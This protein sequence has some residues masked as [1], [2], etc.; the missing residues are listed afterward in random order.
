[1]VA[2][3][4]P[5]G[6]I[7]VEHR[8]RDIRAVERRVLSVLAQFAAIAA[9][10]MRNAV[11]LRHVQDLA[12]RDSLTGV[13]NRYMFQRALERELMPEQMAKR[14]STTASAVLF[15]DLDDFKVVNDTL[16]HAAGDSLLVAVTERIAA[17]VRQGDLVARLGGDEFAVLIEDDAELNRSCAMAERLVRDLGRPYALGEHQVTVTVSIGLASARGSNETVGDVVRN[18]DMAMYMAKANGKAGFAIFDPGMHAAIRERHEL[19]AQLQRAVELEQLRLVYQPIVDLE[20]GTLAGVEALV[21]WEHPERGLVAP[22][23]FIE[24]AE[25]NGAIL[26]IGRWVLREACRD[27]TRWIGNGDPAIGM[28]LCV[29]VSAREIQQ[30]GFV[31]AV[32]EILAE[33]G[34]SPTGLV[35]EITETA[36]LKA[37]PATVATLTA[38]RELGVRIMI[39]DFGTGYFSLSHLRQFPVDALKIAGEFVQASAGDSRSAVLAGAVV[40]LSQSLDIQTVAEGIETV[41]HAERMRALGATYGQGFYFARPASRAEL[42]ARF[43]LDSTYP[44]QPTPAVTPM[45]RPGRRV[46]PLRPPV[47][48]DPTAA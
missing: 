47:A 15:I 33:A 22:G 39:D 27:A 24:I 16:G 1:M 36:L 37:T 32:S 7:V 45:P 46:A 18:A 42:E 38:L 12:E 10:N 26:P 28:F 14:S 9:L 3:G 29:N 34:M 11:L 25:E 19:A 44:A 40:A 13:A 5:V 31:E 17:S 41:D 8:S 35:V 20:A 43:D 4:R 23:S 21:R 48:V 2:D 6:A 30:P